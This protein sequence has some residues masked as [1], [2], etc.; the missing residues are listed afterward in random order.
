[1]DF[2]I[3]LRLTQSHPSPMIPPQNVCTVRPYKCCFKRFATLKLRP[4]TNEQIFVFAQNMLLQPDKLKSEA[5][6]CCWRSPMFFH[7][8]NFR[9]I[10]QGNKFF[11]SA[12]FEVEEVV[13]KLL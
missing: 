10:S 1:M 12:R 11:A 8:L 7:I 5:T 6:S 2:T 13:A 4:Q 3:K 9:E